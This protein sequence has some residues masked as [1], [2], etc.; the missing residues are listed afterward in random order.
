M[1]FDTVLVA[2][3]VIQLLVFSVFDTEWMICLKV[4]TV[5]MDNTIFV[6]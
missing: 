1:L 5:Y 6:Y 4:Q 2:M 3:V